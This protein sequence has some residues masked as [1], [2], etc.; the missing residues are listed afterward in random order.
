[1]IK[2]DA[3]LTRGIDHDP[4]R[5]SVVGALVA[6]ASAVDAGFVADGIETPGE[7]SVMRRLGA[8]AG[9]GT[10]LGKPGRAGDVPRSVRL[11]PG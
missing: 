7:L 1:M 9:Q 3:S 8:D 4:A 10:L 2:L 11:D 5:R 6:F